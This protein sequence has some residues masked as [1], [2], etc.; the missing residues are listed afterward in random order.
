MEPV[1]SAPRLFSLRSLG[2]TTLYADNIAMWKDNIW[3]PI[4]GGG[5]VSGSVFSL[6]SIQNCMYVGGSFG[7]V[8]GSNKEPELFQNKSCVRE[9]DPGRHLLVNGIA[10]FC[11][12]NR[13]LENSSLPL[14]ST[15]EPV[16]LKTFGV[17]RIQVRALAAFLPS[18]SGVFGA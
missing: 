4:P 11:W 2:Y 18:S 7:K 17:G 14:F 8:C 10:R 9:T 15:W 5:S 13:T 1:F 3:Y 12:Q 16:K 6:L